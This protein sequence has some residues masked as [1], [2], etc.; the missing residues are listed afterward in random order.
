MFLQIQKGITGRGTHQAHVRARNSCFT[1]GAGSR[2]PAQCRHRRVFRVTLPR[3]KNHLA[4]EFGKFGR[5]SL[6]IN[7]VRV[8]FLSL[9]NRVENSEIG[10]HQ[11]R[12]LLSIANRPHCLPGLHRPDIPR[13]ISRL[14]PVNEQVLGQKRGC[15]HARAVVHETGARQFAHARV[16][17]RIS[18]LPPL[19]RLK[20]FRRIAPR[21]CFELVC[22]PL[23]HVRVVIKE[24]IGKFPPALRRGICA[25]RVCRGALH[26]GLRKCAAG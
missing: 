11:R 6:G 12:N 25:R 18:C 21:K 4:G 13:T 17:N 9:N 5:I 2:H 24:I 22:A 8:K 1:M 14:A 7:S 3:C 15:D 19:P 20:I 16:N 26:R 10:R 23:R